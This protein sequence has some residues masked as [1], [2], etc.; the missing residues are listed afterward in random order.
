[1]PDSSSPL[2]RNL[3]YSVNDRRL[4]VIIMPTE[5]CNFRCVYCYEDFKQGVM[6]EHVVKSVKLLLTRRIPDLDFL[7]ISWFG[8][9]PLL[10]KGIMLDISAHIRQLLESYK[11]IYNGT[12]TTNAFLLNAETF[13][14]LISSGITKYQI[15]L[16]GDKQLHDEIRVTKGKKGTFDRIWSNLM[17]MR[18]SRHEFR[19][20]LRIHYS[21]DTAEQLDS[22]ISRINSDLRGDRRYYIYF[23]SIERLGGPNDHS[24][25]VVQE[26]KKTAVETGLRAKLRPDVQ[27]F[28]LDPSSYVCYAAQPNS[29]VIR[30][31]GEIGKCTV[32]L[33]DQRNRVGVLLD[34]GT[35][36]LDRDKLLPWLKGLETLEPEAL[37]CPMSRIKLVAVDGVH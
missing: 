6:A 31:N 2:V 15:S 13:D 19:V 14:S 7:D 25:N 28:S 1:M 36:K 23:K 26:D 32:A 24:L 30:S 4:N 22:L 10:A 34:D 8:G 21:E 27:T 12:I 20:I 5:Q 17:M 3:L 37:S 18:E 11:V 29:I 35:V 16:D 33:Y 9:E